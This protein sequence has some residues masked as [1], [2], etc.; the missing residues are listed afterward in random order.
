MAI[1]REGEAVLILSPGSPYHQFPQLLFSPSHATLLSIIFPPL[2]CYN[3]PGGYWR[4]AIA[5]YSLNRD[6][7][8]CFC[9]CQSIDRHHT[10]WPRYVLLVTYICPV[11]DWAWETI[12][13][14][15]ADVNKSKRQ[16]FVHISIAEQRHWDRL[17][18]GKAQRA[19]FECF[20]HLE[21]ALCT[22]SMEKL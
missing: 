2:L 18:G 6:R 15:G 4:W 11:S 5:L 8:Q 3:W 16:L 19:N 21:L 7:K 12:L 22:W 20:K 10:G 17:A 1:V 13:Q 9:R 14:I